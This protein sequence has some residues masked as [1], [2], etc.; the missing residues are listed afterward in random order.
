MK[1]L[2][3]FKSFFKKDPEEFTGKTDT[4]RFSDIKDEGG[5]RM[6]TCKECGKRVD[7]T[8]HSEEQCIEEIEKEL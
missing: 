5:S 7:I 1:F 2:E 8:Q 4:Y 6:G 3:S